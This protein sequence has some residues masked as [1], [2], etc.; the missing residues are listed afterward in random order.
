MTRCMI[1]TGGAGFIG[2]A[3]VEKL[4]QEGIKPIVL[5]KLTYAGH[6]ENLAGIPA[7]SYELVVGD[8]ADQPLV[9]ELFRKHQPEAV[10]HLAAESHVDNS[11]TGPQE[12]IQ[13]NVVGNFLLLQS[14]LG[15]YKK[16][17]DAAKRR[18]RF[19]QV[20]TDE[21][22]GSLG[23]TGHFTEA[24][25][26]Q[27]NSPYSAS[28]AAGDH[29]ARAWYHT[30][31]LPVITT[32]CTNNYGARQFP[33]KLIPV[34]IHKA[35]AGEKLPIYG[36]GSNVRDWI[37]VKDHCQ[38]IWL[39]LTKGKVGEVYNFGGRAELDNMSLVKKLCHFLDQ[40]SPR[41]DK[42]P[43]ETQIGF[44]T[45]RLGHDQRYAVDDAKAEQ[46]LGFMRS[47]TLDEGL[48]ATVEWYLNNQQWCAKVQKAA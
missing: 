27:P 6:R 42:Q 16:L 46:E 40:L 34:M 31:G 12:F 43:Y 45:D 36:N 17:D 38:G 41:A 24:S 15:Y 47:V 29:L 4:V 13:T 21:V 5:D 18:F 23:A 9:D 14:A 8:I 26:I 39:A 11:I 22:Y 25:Q 33:E 20:S 35:L 10:L 30:Y 7:G 48:K 1:V 44:V 37:Y 2:C 32:H 3:M 28:K 19:I